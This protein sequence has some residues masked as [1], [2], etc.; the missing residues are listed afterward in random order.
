MITPALALGL[1]LLASPSRETV[2]DDV[3]AMPRP[4]VGLALG[5][6]SAKG[7]A[8]VGVL[9]WLEEHH[10]P[11]DAIA[12]TSTGAFIGG[13]YAAGMS[14][15]DIEELM[16]A[17]DWDLIMRPDI[18]YRLKSFRRKEDDLE[19]AIKLEAGLR[20]GFRLQSGLNPG[21][22]IGLLLSRVAFPYSTVADFDDL[23]IPFRC[24]A[25][26]L[27]T[28]E[29]VILKDGPLGPALRASMAL[30]GTFDPVRL[31]GRL[32]SDGG[33]LNNVPVDVVRGMGAA[34]VIAVSVGGQERDTPAETIGAV[35]NRA[36][37]LMMEQLDEPRLRRADVVILPDLGAL[38]SSDFRQSGAIVALGYAA[39][40]ARAEALLPYALSDAEWDKYQRTRAGRERPKNGPITF[41]EVRGVS[42]EAAIQIADRFDE[43]L[44]QSPDPDTIESTLDWVIGLGRHASAMYH[45]RLRGRDE[46]LGIEIRDKSYGPPFVKFS[47]DVDN[48]DKDVNLTVGA[49]VTVMDPIGAGSEWRIDT[50][51]GSTLGLST[52][53]LKSLGG[54]GPLS[55][56]AFLAPRASYVRTTES[57]YVGSELRAIYSRQRM[58]AGFDLGWIIGRATQFRIG[59]ETA[60]VRNVTRVGDRFPRDQ[61]SEQS[62]RARFSYNGQDRAYLPTRGARFNATASWRLDVPDVARDFGAL[63]AG[64]SAAFRLSNRQHVALSADA[65]MSLG[66]DPPTLYQFTLGGPFRLSSFPPQAFRGSNFALGRVAYRAAIARL[67]DLLGD[68]L[69]V[70]GIVEAGSAFDRAQGARIKTS[71]SGGLVADT[72]LGPF[73]A[74]ASVGN[75]GGVRAYFLIGS[76]I[77]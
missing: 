9:K 63:E 62:A 46:G 40:Q 39:A 24:V 12:G 34:V 6:G 17:A 47:L 42:P 51:L 23:A 15:A 73:F 59:Y 10:I 28:G 72:F 70:T 68:R 35:A 38:G 75:G 32:L 44:G 33:I 36:I 5:G 8:H 49:R 77:R 58:G 69:Y 61:G 4:R 19:Y 1:L 66:G 56:G 14:A 27:E 50:S 52:E 60:F 53:L 30:P 43:V 20:H 29:A 18:P 65:G 54:R 21:H 57:L 16:R 13:A 64:G 7:I 3:P 67:P 11:V 26:D 25:T 74:G 76:L 48:E 2:P 55:R 31:N 41:V 45:R 22:R 37:G 71:F